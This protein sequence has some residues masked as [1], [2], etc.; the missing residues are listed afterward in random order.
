M[1]RDLPA[2][3]DREEYSRQKKQQVAGSEIRA[4]RAGAW[5]WQFREPKDVWFG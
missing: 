2:K 3:R 1:I 5:R 4:N